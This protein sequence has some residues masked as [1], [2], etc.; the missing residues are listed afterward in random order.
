MLENC[1]NLLNCENQLAEAIKPVRL[2]GEIPLS[3]QDIELLARLVREVITPSISKGT[4]Y[5]RTMAPACL[6]CFLVGMGRFY[7]KETGYWPIVE[8]KVGKIDI[9]WKVKWGKIFIQYLEDNDLPRFDE[10]EGLA[11]VTPILGHTCIP[12]CCLDEYFDR[13]LIPLINRDLFNPFDREEVI[14]DL[15]VRQKINKSRLELEKKK[16]EHNVWFKVL[17]Q[18]N[19]DLKN[20]LEKYEDVVSLLAEEEECKRRIEALHGLENAKLTRSNL[21][22]R[23]NDATECIQRLESEG[24]RLWG[25]ITIFRHRYQPI[26]KVKPQIDDVIHN[27]VRFNEE[28]PEALENEKRLLAA[29]ITEW[30]KLSIEPWNDSFSVEIL[31][32]PLEQLLS[33]IEQYQYLQ[34]NQKTIQEKIGNLEA[35]QK[36]A[37]EPPTLVLSLLM[38]I[39]KILIWIV[40]RK[41]LVPQPSE[42]QQLQATYREAEIQLQLQQ[43]RIKGL[44][45]RL[46][47]EKLVLDN[48]TPD[49]HEEL[50]C[51]QQTYIIFVEAREK[52]TKL[53]EEEGQLTGLVQDLAYS[54]D[55]AVDGNL[56]TWVNRLCEVLKEA[57]QSQAAALE[58]KRILEK[59]IRPVLEAARLEYQNLQ[60]DLEK[61]DQQLAELGGGLTQ[62]GLSLLQEVH[63]SQAAGTQTRQNLSSRYSD[64]MV[65]ESELHSQ[66]WDIIRRDLEEVEN[67]IQAVKNE[68]KQIERGF[69]SHPA[70]YFSVDEPIR[71]F[72]LYGGSTAEN[73]L[74]DSVLLFA[75]AK[76]GER[77]EDISD[78]LLPNRI[79]Q[80]FQ[81]RW[82]YYRTK[83]ELKST[84]EEEMNL[85]TGERFRAPQIFFN[86]AAGEVI[87]KF[88]SQRLLRPEHGTTV[89]LDIIGD[90]PANLICTAPL[91]LYNRTRGLVETHLYEDIVL[92][93]LSEKYIFRLK[94]KDNPIREWEIRGISDI[95]RFLAF[96]PISH[97]LITTDHL[98]RSPLIIVIHEMQR[99]HPQECI[100]TEGGFLFGGWKEYVWKE[101][102]LSTI[103]EFSL[104]GDSGQSLVIPLISDLGAG[105]SLIGGNQLEGILSD[106]R[107]VFN[108]PPEF[109]RI[110][111]NDRDDLHLLRISLLP[112][113]ENRTRKSKHYQ[114]DELVT[115]INKHDE[116]W[117][118]IPL[119]VEQFIG[120]NPMGCFTLRVYKPP[121]LDW[122]LSFCIVPQLN[123]SFGQEI[124]LPYREKIP[125][126]IATLT[127]PET[128]T[129][130]PDGPAKLVSS[131]GTSWMVQTPA[132]EN[133]ITG[134]LLCSIVDGERINLPITFSIPKLRWRLQGLDDTQYDRW[135]D[136][137]QEEL[138]IGDW[139][140]AQELFLVVETPWF[141]IG[142]VSLVLPGNSISIEFGKVH[143]QKVRVDLKALE[144]TLRAGPSLE[145]VA[146]SLEDA[147]TKIPDIPLFTVCT[148]WLA[149]KI[150]CFHYPI[151]DT[152]RLDVSWKEKGKANQKTARL[153]YL[154]GDR[155]RL[156]QH[157]LVSQDVQ[158]ATF[159]STATEVKS[160]KYLVHLEPYDPWS[161]RPI[162]PKLNDPNTVIIEIVTKA[163]E[164]A[165]TIRSV[166]VDEH[167]SYPLLQGSYRIH[168]IGKVI[169][170]KLPD[171]LD[172]ED[173]AHVLITPFNEN[174]YVGNLEVKGKPEVIAHLSDTNPVKFEYDTQKSFVTS[175]VDRHGEGAMYC[176]ECNMLFWCQE[177]NL[178]HKHKIYGPIEEFRVVWESE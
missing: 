115:L 33:Q 70:Q 29:V 150:R 74:T 83:E 72:L 39:K 119:N 40:G 14:H 126:V 53:E 28:L 35:S 114:V 136:E 12:D 178:R 19:R 139:I 157:Q 30:A 67:R 68:L 156:I 49:L 92:N 143:D 87:A 168:I 4:R 80:H 81:Q 165:V 141:Y 27:H 22:S 171:N 132:S 50:S 25:E 20:Q 71:R 76:S 153:W 101:V 23:I 10:E 123:A 98:P 116:G 159:I 173:I 62:Q 15:R 75:R 91:K 65:I 155:P 128:S 97:K 147:R 64:L 58:A 7:D 162:C 59:E 46:P 110:P 102:D 175:I 16:K 45:A 60:A 13:V 149:E 37:K 66:G 3:D 146:I 161:S 121:Y 43:D 99:I 21:L 131:D 111:L 32:L 88:P 63:Q 109:I 130:K 42:L 5:L 26:L 107:P 134:M 47:V 154:S 125:D 148:C 127:L 118:D 6:A 41:N 151:G 142:K 105:I 112:E 86:P 82:E 144:D 31:Q 69:D 95:N 140:E 133:E 163:P 177:T 103:E 167:H 135:F 79:I 84:L 169:N 104:S 90:D 18:K 17:Q 51:L 152:V 176:F 57:Q 160:G 44:F 93:K 2:L 56:N 1:T 52:R 89:Q 73:Y 166:G 8:E 117:I 55:V 11:Y 9:N 172:I 54:F 77:V 38:L 164:K 124:Y 100:L 145:I 170:Q 96:S 34:G 106:E 24:K 122:Q 113:D 85:A 137:V 48:P 94:S 158:E 174:W 36:E 61:L 120:T 78:I 129:F 108:I 138:W